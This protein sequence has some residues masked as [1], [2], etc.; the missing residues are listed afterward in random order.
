ML[1]STDAKFFCAV[2]IKGSVSL[3]VLM[4]GVTATA[5]D[6]F[7]FG[8]FYFFPGNLLVRRS[9]YDN[10]PN[11]V[12]QGTILPPGCAKTQVACPTTPAP[13]N[14]TYPFVWNNDAYDGSFGI[15]SKIF[16]DQMTVFG[17]T[18][19][20]LEVPNSSLRNIGATSDQM[21]TKASVQRA[22]WH[23]IF[24]PTENI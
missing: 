22:N 3:C 23:C 9:V 11:N 2:T 7:G 18:L 6:D 21:V 4:T 10:N 17:W 24:P 15:T 1:T 8:G 19:N 5:D 13:D 20:S 14:G 16:L 12:P